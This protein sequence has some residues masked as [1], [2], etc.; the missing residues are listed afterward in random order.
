MYIRQS[1]KS[2]LKISKFAILH[3]VTLNV[4]EILRFALS[5]TVS[6]ISA[7]LKFFNFLNFFEIFEMFKNV[8]L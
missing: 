1:E 8:L 4:S 6:E 5:L 7:N 2:K 3:A